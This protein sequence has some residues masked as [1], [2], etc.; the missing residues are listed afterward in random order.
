MKTAEIFIN[1]IELGLKYANEGLVVDIEFNQYGLVFRGRLFDLRY[2][3]IWSRSELKYLHD[4]VSIETLMDMF[5][6]EIFSK[7]KEIT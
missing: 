2:N 3:R 5:T 1:L 6:D 4:D 7:L